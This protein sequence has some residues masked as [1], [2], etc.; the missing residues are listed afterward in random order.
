MCGR[1]ADEM[2]DR[3][4]I[5]HMRV[6]MASPEPTKP[7][8]NIA[9]SQTAPIIR[10]HDE[11]LQL[12][13]VRWQ[14]YEAWW[15]KMSTPIGPQINARAD[16]VF[17]N[18]MYKHSMKSRR[19]LVLSTGWYEWNR[20]RKGEP[21]RF[22]HM[23]DSRPILFGGI[24]TRYYDKEKDVGNDNFAIITT[25]AHEKMQSFHDRMPVIINPR[26]YAKWLDPENQDE[27]WLQQRLEPYKGRDL[28]IIQVSK[29][30]NN[31]RN[32]GPECIKPS[33]AGE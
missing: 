2:L 33:S 8:Y 30:V 12:D 23:K 24:W 29:Y 16:K 3:E 4:Y 5:E 25:D 7:R 32:H 20:K 9:P 26:D 15:A 10:W 31:V 1:Y 17:K 11:K 28:E 14:L 22:I 6:I 18:A 27:K 21:P 19:C 13:D